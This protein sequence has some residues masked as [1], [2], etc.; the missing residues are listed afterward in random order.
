M[1]HSTLNAVLSPIVSEFGTQSQADSYKAWLD[2]KLQRAEKSAADQPMI[3]HDQ[4][5]GQIRSLLEAKEQ[6]QKRAALSS[7]VK[8]KSVMSKVRDVP[9]RAGDEL[10]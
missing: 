7:R 4:A 6:L 9:A 10:P 5:M 1:N 2:L 3:P 8:L